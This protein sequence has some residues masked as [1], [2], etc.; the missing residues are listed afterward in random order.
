M[1]AIRV[2]RHPLTLLTA[3]TALLG[4]FLG[5]AP[6]T[7]VLGLWA[8]ML[9]GLAALQ[10][11]VILGALVFH[12]RIH[13]V[14]IGVGK[15]WKEWTTPRRTISLRAI[16][17][18]ISVAV[19]PGRAPARTRMWRA[20]AVSAAVALLL[21]CG[22]VLW[23][24]TGGS[25]AWG[26]AIGTAYATVVGLV[27]RKT[28]ASTS[29]GWYLFRLPR[30]DG[31][32][33]EQLDAAPVVARTVDAAQAGNLREAAELAGGLA[34]DYPHLRT[35]TAARILVLEAEGRYAEA[36]MLAMAL[37]GDAEQTPQ[38]AAVSFAA[39][40]GLACATVEAGHLDA[41]LGLGTAVQAFENAETLGYP[42]HKLN[43][44]RAL[45]ELLRG[46]AA[47]AVSL[48]RLSADATDDRLS[49]ADDLATL[50]RAHMVAGDNAAARAALVEAERLVPWWPRVVATRARLDVGA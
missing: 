29:T 25:F 19:G 2:L 6:L 31:V 21:V 50:A 12:V 45:L 35:A 24:A 41:E 38:E 42:G 30:L 39:L 34:K 36:L 20:A 16:P 4:Y 13:Q 1:P 22:A 49:R 32:R 3:G 9:V 40:A 47:R 27:P 44:A 10:V 28:A 11:G 48:A 43:G 26:A 14:V 23:A 37:A 33:A 7:P 8:G 15:R 46:N 5:R 18:L 17:L